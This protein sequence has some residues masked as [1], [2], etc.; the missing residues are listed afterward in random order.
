MADGDAG[1]P[2]LGHTVA[3]CGGLQLCR[4]FAERS[5]KDAAVDWFAL[6]GFD[7]IP[8]AKTSWNIL[9]EARIT[10][11]LHPCFNTDFVF[12]IK[13]LIFSIKVKSA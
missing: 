5:R 1:R 7:A 13:I 11:S 12:S 6:E 3:G 2:L 10:Q 4:C 9:T 8:T